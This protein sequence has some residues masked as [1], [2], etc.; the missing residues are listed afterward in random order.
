L[1]ET[2]ILVGLTIERMI[3]PTTEHSIPYA[4]LVLFNVIL[5]S[6]FAI[7]GVLNE[8]MFILLGFNFLSTFILAAV[9]YQFFDKQSRNTTEK[10]VLDIRLAAVCIFTPSNFVLSFFAFRS[11]GWRIYRRIGASV[12]LKFMYRIYQVFVSLIRLDLQFGVNLILIAGLF[13]FRNYE[14]WIDVA[15]MLLTFGWAVMGWKAVRIEN[16]TGC[17]LFL[18][19]AFLH[20]AYLLYKFIHF[21]SHGEEVLEKHDFSLPLLYFVGCVFLLWRVLLIIWTFWC[22]RNFG[23]GLSEVLNKKSDEEKLLVDNVVD[24][25]VNNR[26]Y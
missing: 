1:I 7:D 15:V 8:N 11:W 3:H 25:N 16:K 4:A 9:V 24:A 23:H 22:M 5:L 19:F 6:I 20:P 14:L 10:L 12:H 17:Y 26:F 2:I 21:A 18:V 13:L